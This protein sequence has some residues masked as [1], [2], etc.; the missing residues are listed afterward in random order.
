M[1]VMIDLETLGTLPGSIILSL[2][3]C[4]FNRTAI[5]ERLEINIDPASCQR[6]GLRIDAGTVL[7]WMGRDADA[8]SAIL[9]A[10]T[11]SLHSALEDFD[12]W[13]R[14]H[15]PGKGLRLWSNGPSFDA[16][17]LRSAYKAAGMQAPWEYWNERC[18]R[19]MLD[20]GRVRLLDFRV[21]S[22]E[23]YHAALGDAIVQTRAVQ[24]A[25]DQISAPMPVAA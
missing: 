1:D 16:V 15:A 13:L 8:R 12:A 7:W 11:V 18:V 4:T 21:G 23:I 10:P 17:L 3:A 14:A 20:L 2:G 22:G 5:L 9:N 24:A 19:T 25:W 6:L